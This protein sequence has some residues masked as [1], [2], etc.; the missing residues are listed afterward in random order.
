MFPSLLDTLEEEL[1]KPTNAT[2]TIFACHFN[3]GMIF[4]LTHVRSRKSNRNLIEILSDP[5]YRIAAYINGHTHPEHNFEVLH[6][7]GIV[8][9]TGR[10]IVDFD[11]F[12]VLTVD[13][14]RLAYVEMDGSRHAMV[15]S[16]GRD[17]LAAQIFTTRDFD[18]RVLSF[19]ENVTVFHVSGAVTGDLR[20]ER[21][22]ASGQDLYS[23]HCSLPNGRHTITISGDLDETINFSIG[24]S[25]GPFLETQ[26][27]DVIGWMFTVSGI[28]GAVNVIVILVSI[29]WL[30]SIIE[31]GFEK[32]FAYLNGDSSSFGILGPLLGP[33]F[34]GFLLRRLP[35]SA[36]NCL[37]FIMLYAF[38]F[39]IGIS[40]IEDKVNVQT[41]YGYFVDGHFKYD[42]C[43]QLFGHCYFNG[44][45]GGFA[46]VFAL[47]SFESNWGHIIDLL[48]GIVTV[49]QAIGAWESYGH[50]TFVDGTIFRISL[51]F[52]VLPA[53]ATILLLSV[54]VHRGAKVKS[55]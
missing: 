19:W 24:V 10:A 48:L 23:L 49:A 39:P 3:T 31:R 2:T 55:E 27:S 28:L 5:K 6:I 4:P 35:K 20:F 46:A 37:I 21:K 47:Y 30:P 34:V 36:R 45:A 13:N 52:H 41:I 11:L 7:G 26:S 15:T 40:K 25:A 38:V 8:E 18:I 17:E 29:L 51:G 43:A 53:A 22:T 1:E 14:G 9:I 16:P 44:I 33:L 32:S 42:C 50:E 12:N 54:F